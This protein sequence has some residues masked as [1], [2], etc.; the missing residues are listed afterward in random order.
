MQVLKFTPEFRREQF[1]AGR[2]LFFYCKGILG[3]KDMTED[4]HW[5]YCRFLMRPHNRKLVSVFRGSLK[6]SI[7]N[8]GLTS[9][10]SIYIPNFATKLVE[11]K[12]DNA[13]RNHFRPIY[14][15]FVHSDRADYLYWLYGEYGDDEA[16]DP[17]GRFLDADMRRIP[18]G[19]RGWNT[20][21][22]DFKRTDA[23]AAPAV[24]YGGVDS[25]YEGWHGNRVL[26]D[27]LEGADADKGDAPN[28]E[29]WHFVSQR[30][31]PLLKNPH[32]D[33]ILVIGTPHGLDPVVWK[34]REWEEAHRKAGN[35]PVWDI[36][37]EPILDASGN[38]RWPERFTKTVIAGL[39]MNPEMWEKQY[40]L[41]KGHSGMYIFDL[42]KIEKFNWDWEVKGHLISYPAPVFNLDNLDEQ[43]YPTVDTEIRRLNPW[44]L[45]YYM[46]CDPKHKERAKWSDSEAAIVVVGVHHD[47]HAF[48]MDTWAGDVSLDEYAEKVYWYYRK[49][50]PVCVTMEAIGAQTWFWDYARLLEKGKYNQILSLP[51]NGKIQ[52]L[53]KLSNRLVEADKKSENKEVWTIQQLESWFNLGTLHL[54]KNQEHLKAQI[55]AFPEPTGLRDLL[56]SLSQGPPVWKTPIAPQEIERQKR[57]AGRVE[58]LQP[59]DPFTGYFN[60]LV[61]TEGTLIPN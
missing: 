43:G 13:Y 52:A 32:E 10:D 3:F 19:F 29:A 37:W 42:E 27:D 40:M 38:C 16:K 22:I 12:A 31:V 8:V 34:I 4:L 36:F 9:H 7:G 2:D 48:V 33:Q 39:K 51:R 11:Q 26:G 20:D 55:K 14:D 50:M 45:R 49:W 17:R 5:D 35:P 18:E 30:A 57:I 58:L 25:R 21:Q 47:G 61:P 60:P 46:H 15:L 44:G 1:E 59:A 28:R 56:D 41:Q 54:H 23:L 53:P 6:S 24:T